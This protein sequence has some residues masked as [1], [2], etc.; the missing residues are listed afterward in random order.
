MI[1][2]VNPGISA[3][4]RYGVDIGEIGGH[5]MPLGIFYLSSYLKSKGI[6]TEVI[7][8]ESEG[9]RIDDISK[10]ALGKKVFGILAC[11]FDFDRL[12]LK[13]FARWTLN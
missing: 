5:Q 8:A 6:V 11:K 7:D 10:R 13:F 2:I 12:L 1:L 4:E 3:Q 9:Q